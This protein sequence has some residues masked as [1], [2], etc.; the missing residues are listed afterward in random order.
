[1]LRI[2]HLRALAR[3]THRNGK[4]RNVSPPAHVPNRDRRTREHLTPA[5]AER[6]IAATGEA[7]T[8]LSP[9]RFKGFWR[10]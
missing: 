3:P 4:V 8:D 6:L 1:M 2:T 9:E 5:A 7:R 10:D